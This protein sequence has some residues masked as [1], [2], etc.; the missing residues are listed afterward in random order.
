MPQYTVQAAVGTMQ[1]KPR[2]EEVQQ[3]D[4]HDLNS[5]TSHSVTTQ[6]AMHATQPCWES[7]KAFPAPRPAEPEPKLFHPPVCE[8]NT[9]L[10]SFA[11]PAP[12]G[13]RKGSLAE[14][15]GNGKRKAQERRS[16]RWRGVVRTDIMA[17]INVA[18]WRQQ[19]IISKGK[20]LAL[21]P[22]H[23]SGQ[24]FE[25]HT[26]KDGMTGSAVAKLLNHNWDAENP[27]AQ[28]FERNESFTE[29]GA[30]E[31]D[32]IGER[33]SESDRKAEKDAAW[34]NSCLKKDGEPVRTVS[35]SGIDRALVI[36]GMVHE[37]SSSDGQEGSTE[38]TRPA[39]ERKRG[40]AMGTD[41]R[42]ADSRAADSNNEVTLDI[43][44]N[45]N[46]ETAQWVVTGCEAAD[47]CLS[48]VW[49][50]LVPTALKQRYPVCTPPRTH[51]AHMSNDIFNTFESISWSRRGCD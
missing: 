17:R 4:F 5:V 49:D 2:A 45:A 8:E 46:L 20:Y 32:A 19:E 43:E 9:P 39:A 22:A 6:V 42:P 26:G 50:Y 48:V 7:Q 12:G 47:A 41:A 18:E 44:G 33:K 25:L 23:E 16:R 27:F 21:F 24:R 34:A 30:E 15:A 11:R 3:A 29:I 13:K 14:E 10:Q 28:P 35:T 51:T 36:G 1:P 40:H 38:D 31:F 37:S